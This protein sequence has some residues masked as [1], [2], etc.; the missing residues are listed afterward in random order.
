MYISLRDIKN[1]T[2]SAKLI[3]TNNYVSDESQN[4]FQHVFQSTLL[5]TEGLWEAV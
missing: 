5:L 2:I 3:Y 4:H 1:T